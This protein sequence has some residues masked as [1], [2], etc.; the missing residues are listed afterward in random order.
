MLLQGAPLCF[1]AVLAETATLT[2]AAILAAHAQQYTDRPE[3]TIERTGYGI[4]SRDFE[5]PDVL[6]VYLGTIR[7]DQDQMAFSGVETCRDEF[8]I[9]TNIDDMNPEIYSH[10]EERLMAAGA[11]DVYKTPIIMKKGRPSV[12][13]SILAD[14]AAQKEILDVIFT[15]TTSI[16]VR[17]FAVEKIMLPRTFSTIKTRY[18]EVLIKNAFYRGDFLKYK[19]EYE[20]CRRLAKENGIPLIEIYREIESEMRRT[21]Q[22]PPMDRQ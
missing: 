16:G 14:A 11:L 20:D 8:I 17:R 7:T 4:G 15:E 3:F 5:I 10:V 6:R 19:A 21:G 12:K 18:G 9:E 2:G 13:L 22:L 1:G